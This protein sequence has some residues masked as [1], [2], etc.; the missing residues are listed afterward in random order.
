M[1]HRVYT[2]YDSK[3]EIY[4]Q[5]IYFRADGEALRAFKASLNSNGHQFASNPADYTLFAIGEYDDDKAQFV[6]YD[7]HVNLGN[8]ARFKE[9]DGNG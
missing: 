2:V 7:A 1:R 3:A 6:N 5:P 9:D 8:G 4:M